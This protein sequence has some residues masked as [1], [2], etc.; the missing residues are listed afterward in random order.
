M[1]LPWREENET[2][3][4]LVEDDFIKIPR[5]IIKNN[6]QL[7]FCMD[8]MFINQQALFTTTEKDIWSWGL[9]W[10]DNRTKEDYYRYF[11]VVMKYYKK[12]GF[13]VKCIECDGGF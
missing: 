1:C 4:K 11:C 13:A 9:V 5:E 6:Q 10:I 7:I 8:I 12:V 2:D 3:I